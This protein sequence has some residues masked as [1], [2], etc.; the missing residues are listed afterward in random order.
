MLGSLKWKLIVSG[1]SVLIQK[2]N[3]LSLRMICGFLSCYSCAT[4]YVLL[5]EEEAT[6]IVDA[7][8]YFKQALKA[9]EMIYRRSQNCHSQSPQHEAQLSKQFWI[10]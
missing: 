10:K 7:E 4:A 1:S 6:T 9:G 8:R 2:Q 3:P 5:A